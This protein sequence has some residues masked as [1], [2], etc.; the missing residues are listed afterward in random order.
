MN[1][2]DVYPITMLLAAKEAREKHA[3][4]SKVF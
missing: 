1:H 4:G 2:F 3:F